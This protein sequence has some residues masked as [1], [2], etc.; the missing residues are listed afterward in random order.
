MPKF[1][2][3]ITFAFCNRK[4]KCQYEHCDAARASHVGKTVYL[5]LICCDEAERPTYIPVW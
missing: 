2:H 4:D 1:Y 3:K 5:L